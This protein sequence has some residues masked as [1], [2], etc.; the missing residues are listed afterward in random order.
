MLRS[1]HPCLWSKKNVRGSFAITGNIF[2]WNPQ[3]IPGWQ[4][5]W[6]PHQRA[7]TLMLLLPQCCSFIIYKIIQT[8][9]QLFK[10]PSGER[11]GNERCHLTRW[12]CTNTGFSKERNRANTN[13]HWI[14]YTYYFVGCRRTI[15]FSLRGIISICSVSL[16]FWP[17]LRRIIKHVTTV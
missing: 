13:Y 5:H 17:T 11:D 9:M 16:R 2:I 1:P 7:V 10:F 15:D 12:T 8:K 14:L 6:A 3:M 4:I